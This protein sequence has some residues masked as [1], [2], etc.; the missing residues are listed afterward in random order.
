MS[1]NYS[2]ALRNARADVIQSQVGASPKL[3]IYSGSKPASVSDPASGTLLAELTLP[4]VWLNAAAS[5]ALTQAGV[6]TVAAALATGTAG[7]YRIYDNAGTTS[8]IQGSVPSDLV[9]NPTNA[10]TAGAG[11]TVTAFTL[12]EGNP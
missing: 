1:V 7:Y 8:H 6:W 9:G 12:T 10:I 3:R 5:G 2:T 4:A 11:V